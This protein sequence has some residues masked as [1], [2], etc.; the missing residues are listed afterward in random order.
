[1]LDEGIRYLELRAVWGTNL[2]ALM[3]DQVATIK[4]TLDAHGIGVS[5]I[6]SPI[7]K[8]RIDTPFDIELGRFERA[9]A[10]AHIFETPFIRIFSFYPPD[11]T[12]QTGLGLE[13]VERLHRLVADAEEAGVTLLHENEKDIF[14]D[15]VEGC[16]EIFRRVDSNHLYAAFDPANFLQCGEQPYPEAYDALRPW[17]RAVHVKDARSDGTIVPAGEGEARWPE[18]LQR[19][20]RD[21]YDGFLALEPHLASVGQLQGF[22]GPELFRRASQA[23]Q[24]ILRGMEWEHR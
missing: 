3:D 10:L 2:L 7:G 18:L 9:L 17:I 22:S 16:L 11:H 20:R 6:A 21:G 5:A 14:G 8:T 12:H 15:T 23:L 1:M 4:Q 19:L 13:V 24:G